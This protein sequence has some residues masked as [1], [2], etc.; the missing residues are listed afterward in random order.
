E[1]GITRW[2]GLEALA[3]RQIAV[4]GGWHGVRA[5]FGVSQTGEPELGWTALGAAAG[6]TSH[7]A[8]AALRVVARR[9]RASPGLPGPPGPGAGARPAA[10]RRHRHRGL[11]ARADGGGRGGKPSRAG[12]DHAARHRA[13][14]R[15]GAVRRPALAV[16]VL[17]A[18]ILT[19]DG[20]W[21]AE[22]A[23]AEPPVA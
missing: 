9:D 17:V 1:S 16:V 6:G 21:A 23:A 12:L 20:G 22:E 18:L 15:T 5:A 2:F 13:P 11:V 3:T 4:C 14:L 10:A 7:A 8:G 19:V